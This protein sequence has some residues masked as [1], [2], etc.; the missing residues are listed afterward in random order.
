MQVG[1]IIAIFGKVQGVGFRYSAKKEALRLGINGFVK[2]IYDG[3]VYMEVEGEQQNVD[4]F[5]NWCYN[6]NAQARIE[7]VELQ[8]CPPSGYYDFEIR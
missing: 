4:I 5:I 3:S 6:G 1:Y 7:N 8:K 2:N